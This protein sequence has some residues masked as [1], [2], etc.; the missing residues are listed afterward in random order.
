MRPIYLKRSLIQSILSNALDSVHAYLNI[1]DGSI[2][3]VTPAA[4]ATQKVLIP[5]LTDVAEAA[6]VLAES[7]HLQE[8][9]RWETLNAAK[10][11]GEDTPYHKIPLDDV[12]RAYDDMLAFIKT[13][14]EMR[15]RERL[16]ID[17]EQEW[18]FKKFETTLGR[19]AAE[20]DRWFE[21]QQK[22]R[23]KRFVL[24]LAEQGYYPEWDKPA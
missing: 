14:R 15:L 19:H 23:F 10:V 24:W 3:F 17:V 8:W 5:N 11:I 21:F 7:D 18:P 20:R 4:R 12:D 6:D 22:E 16:L 9:Q 1:D 2:M 13:V